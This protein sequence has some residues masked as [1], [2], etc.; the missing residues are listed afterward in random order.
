MQSFVSSINIFPGSWRQ[1]AQL[2]RDTDHDRTRVLCHRPAQGDDDQDHN[3]IQ[4]KK[5][6]K[7]NINWHLRF[8]LSGCEL[9][10]VQDHR[11]DV[12]GGRR[13]VTILGS[14]SKIQAAIK[15]LFPN[16][17]SFYKFFYGFTL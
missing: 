1:P 6:L 8:F 10:H 3:L 16:Q 13:R 12:R 14:K 2:R 7:K 5:D 11:L 4:Y 15:I 17:A 9:K